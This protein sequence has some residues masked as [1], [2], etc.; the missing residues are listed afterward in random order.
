MTKFYLANSIFLLFASLVLSSGR[1]SAQDFCENKADPELRRLLTQK[2]DTFGTLLYVSQLKLARKLAEDHEKREIL[3]KEIIKQMHEMDPIEAS[4][5]EG[6]ALESYL[7]Y[8]EQDV[9]KAA[10]ELVAIS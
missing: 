10:E 8:G 3:E 5:L 9:S 4:K 1:L 2:T 6:K 7:A